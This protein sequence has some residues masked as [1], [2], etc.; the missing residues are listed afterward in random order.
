MNKRGIGFLVILFSMLILVILSLIYL[1]TKNPSPEVPASQDETCNSLYVTNPEGGINFV[2]ISDDKTSAQRYVDYFH[3]TFPYSNYKD[4]FNFYQVDSAEIACEEYKG[5][6]ILC[7]SAENRKKASVCPHDFIIALKSAGNLRSSALKNFMSLN[8]NHPTSVFTHELGH[9]LL[10]FAE[11]YTGANLQ[12]GQPNCKYS[13]DEF[14]GHVDSCAE[15]C[16]KDDYYRSI[17]D[18]IMRTLSVNEYG[19]YNTQ[20]I[21]D[22]IEKNTRPS[23]TSLTGSAIFDQEYCSTQSYY[24]IIYN[25]ELQTTI[26]SVQQ[27]CAPTAGGEGEDSYAVSSADGTVIHGI[28]FT[29]T[30]FTESPNE[31]NYGDIVGSVIT[32]LSELPPLIFAL[33]KMSGAET[34]TIK[35]SNKVLT[36]LNLKEIGGLACTI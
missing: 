13:C 24:Q 5:I 7:D 32:E 14:G 21:I 12:R 28:Q 8:L 30:L 22:Y 31:E 11:E 4:R 2:F 9:A 34:L 16:S 15:G 25:P 35:Q 26:S 19:E 10:S 1:A 17:P 36:K 27:G 3:K 23:S 33:P 29:L 6:A 18:G 20:L